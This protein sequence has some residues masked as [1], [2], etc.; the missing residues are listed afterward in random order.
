MIYAPKTL[1]CSKCR[2]IF[3][4]CTRDQFDA[5]ECIGPDAARE[6]EYDRIDR[7]IDPDN[8][9]SPRIAVELVRM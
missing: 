5:H 3:H 9:P 8:K 6:D 2:L 7:A 4:R 1:M